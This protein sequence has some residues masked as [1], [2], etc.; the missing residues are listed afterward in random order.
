V[1]LLWVPSKIEKAAQFNGFFLNN[2]NRVYL[3]FFSEPASFHNK[4][5]LPGNIP[6]PGTATFSAVEHK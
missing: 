3:A 6:L 1:A 2:L 4:R 5:F